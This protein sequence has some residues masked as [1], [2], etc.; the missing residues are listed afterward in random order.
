MKEKSIY[1]FMLV[2]GWVTF[3]MIGF[4]DG[5][6]HSFLGAVLWSGVQVGALAIAI[7][8]SVGIYMENKKK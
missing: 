7:L 3:A 6:A 4:T 2:F 1:I 8:G 5:I